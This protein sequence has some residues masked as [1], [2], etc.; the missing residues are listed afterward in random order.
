MNRVRLVI[1]DQSEQVV[2]LM[3]TKMTQLVYVSN[4]P[5]EPSMLTL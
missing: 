3:S 2:I 1:M 4:D 5:M